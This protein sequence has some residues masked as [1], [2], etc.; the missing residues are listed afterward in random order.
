MAFPSYRYDN[1]RNLDGFKGTIRTK[2]VPLSISSSS[3]KPSSPSM[4]IPT[5]DLSA[6]S[7]DSTS[8][9]TSISESMTALVIR[10]G[11]ES[12]DQPYIK[13]RSMSTHTSDVQS[14]DPPVGMYRGQWKNWRYHGNG[15]LM[16]HAGN[17][18]YEGQW[19]DGLRWGKGRCH[20]FDSYGCRW[21]YEGD[22]VQVRFSETSRLL[23]NMW[24]G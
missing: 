13:S 16:D 7:S 18:V 23:I 4:S 8:L 3:Q 17:V 11:P 5:A 20:F 6:S 19:R 9:M 14:S 15:S 21:L 2:E 12:S 1:H 24:A 22:F 10:D